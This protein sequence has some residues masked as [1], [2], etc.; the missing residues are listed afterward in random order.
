MKNRKAGSSPWSR[1][2]LRELRLFSVTSAF[3]LVLF[4]WG[5]AALIMSQR[6]GITPAQVEAVIRATA[7]DIGAPGKDDEFGYG[8]IQPRNALFGQGIRR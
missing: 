5:L 4:A 8:L 1:A 3:V 6:P 7:K 2:F